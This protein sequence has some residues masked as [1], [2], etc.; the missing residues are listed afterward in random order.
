MVPFADFLFV[1]IYENKIKRKKVE[2]SDAIWVVYPSHAKYGKKKEP[3]SSD[4]SLDN[5]KNNPNNA[6]VLQGGI[7]NGE[8]INMR[9]AFKPTA[10][11]GVCLPF[12]PIFLFTC[13]FSFHSKLFCSSGHID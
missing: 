8:I 1:F 11:I 9:I 10:T 6:D 5:L 13:V 2:M 3:C 12:S 4:P 7:S